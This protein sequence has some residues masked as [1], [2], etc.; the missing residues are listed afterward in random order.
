M[1]NRSLMILL[2]SSRSSKKNRFRQRDK[3]SNNLISFKIST[4]QIPSHHNLILINRWTPSRMSFFHLKSIHHKLLTQSS[5]LNSFMEISTT[6]LYVPQGLRSPQI[7]Q[8]FF[9]VE[10][11]SVKSA[12]D[13]RSNPRHS[14]RLI[15]ASERPRDSLHA[16]YAS[17]FTYLR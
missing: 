5:Y 13:H 2:R 9:F 1:N 4:L 17:K 8:G 6:V 11:V 10:T 3:G 14:V 15:R 12:F 7:C 16:L